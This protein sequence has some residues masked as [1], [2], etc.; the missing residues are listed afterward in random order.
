[1][2]SAGLARSR[3]G[4]DGR[5]ES[6]ARRRPDVVCEGLRLDACWRS[7]RL[8]CERHEGSEVN[9]RAAVT[10]RQ[11]VITLLRL[12]IIRDRVITAC[13]I[14]GCV[15]AACMIARGIMNMRH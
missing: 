6:G 9:T 11:C 1:M 2:K 3:L 12:G 10:V 14:P 5:S 7:R 4:E 13:L 8:R 15:I